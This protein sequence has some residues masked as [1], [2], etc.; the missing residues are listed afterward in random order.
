MLSKKAMQVSYVSNMISI[1]MN[2]EQHMLTEYNGKM[3]D[4][5]VA[6]GAGAVLTI[7]TKY[8]RSEAYF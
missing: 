3:V 7:G 8:R 2:K 6:K 1:G 5:L 4:T